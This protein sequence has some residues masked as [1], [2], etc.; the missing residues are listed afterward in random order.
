MLEQAGLSRNK[1]KSNTCDML[2][3]NISMELNLVTMLY[4]KEERCEYELREEWASQ[5]TKWK[6]KE[7][8]Q[9][10]YWSSVSQ[11][12]LHLRWGVTKD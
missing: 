3:I 2:L 6:H 11:R 1:S 9:F 12:N 7:A 4:V 5:I 8:Q 10:I